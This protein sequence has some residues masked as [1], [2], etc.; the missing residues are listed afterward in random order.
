MESFAVTRIGGTV[1]FYG[2]A[3]GDPASVDPRMLM[4]TS[5]TSKRG[6]SLECFHF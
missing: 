4:D 1:V 6:R 5:K 2:M 3:G